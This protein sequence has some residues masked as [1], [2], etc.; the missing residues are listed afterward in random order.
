MVTGWE[1]WEPLHGPKRLCIVLYEGERYQAKYRDE[2][3]FNIE[4]PKRCGDGNWDH[5][6]P[7][8][9]FT[10]WGLSPAS[11]RWE[12]VR[13]QVDVPGCTPVYNNPMVKPAQLL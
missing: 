7:G 12:F 8:T 2:N 3:G 4:T 11:G 5:R 1:W 13:R 10:I 6:F 9:L